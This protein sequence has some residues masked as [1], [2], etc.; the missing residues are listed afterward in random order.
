M[1]VTP[2]NEPHSNTREAA[3][4]AWAAF[5][6]HVAEYSARR[7]HIEEGHSNVSRL[8]GSIRH[9]TLLEDEIISETLARHSFTASQKWLQEVCW[10]RYWK[11]WLEMHPQIWKAWRRRVS[12]LPRQLSPAMQAR[13]AA[14]IAGQSGVACMDLIA[15]E[16]IATGYLHNHARM[17]WASFWTHVE[18]LPWELGADFF[19]KHLLDADPASN[20]LSWRW[21][22]GLQTAGKSY[23]VRLSNIEKYAPSYLS[24]SMEG[25]AKLADGAVNPRSLRDEVE[26]TEHPLAQHP[27]EYAQTKERTGLWLHADDLT[28][29]IGPL[30]AL[31][32]TSV[33]VA[34]TEPVYRNVYGLSELRIRSLR[35]VLKDGITRS[36]GHF[37]CHAAVI[38]EEDPAAGLCQW[39]GDQALSLVVAFAPTVGPVADMLPNLRQRL[40]AVGTRLVLI[41]RASDKTAYSYATAGFFPFWQKMSGHLTTL[42]PK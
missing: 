25:S 22:A 16:L 30:S 11:G 6:P 21:V 27:T 8:S 18:G 10:R 23:L 39:A 38:E 41:Q 35:A 15:R 19:F 7:N 28:P 17:W 32:P 5:L 26:L 4:Q 31:Q 1:A 29:E 33:A 40:E 20:T 14:L 36:A 34:I 42:Y 13:A 12:I 24:G 3:L 37:G 9:R 2:F